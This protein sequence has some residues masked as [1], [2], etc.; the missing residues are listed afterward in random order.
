MG[1]TWNN[2]NKYKFGDSVPWPGY[3]KIWQ[4]WTHS[5]EVRVPVCESWHT[6]TWVCWRFLAVGVANLPAVPSTCPMRTVARTAEMNKNMY[7]YT[8]TSVCQ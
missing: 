7:I 4:W 6:L 1:I 5:I 2:V 8:E 3:A